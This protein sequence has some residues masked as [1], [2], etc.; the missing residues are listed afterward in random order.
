M[1]KMDMQRSAPVYWEQSVES[2]NTR[3]LALANKGAVSGTVFYADSQSGGKGRHGRSFISPEGGLYMSMLI[4]PS[5]EAEKCSQ[6]TP[7]AAVAAHR[8][9]KAC[10]GL[11]ADIKWPNDLQLGGK[12]LCG[13]LTELSFD[14]KGKPQIIIGIGINLNTPSF[15]EEL[16]DIACSVYSHSGKSIKKESLLE[17]LVKELDVYIARWE[18][19]GNFFLEEYRSLSVCADR[20]VIVISGTESK[21]AKALGIN[22]DFGL[23]VR[24]EDGIEESIFFGEVSL[25][26]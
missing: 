19:E 8:A 16:E 4:R 14:Q 13:I 1:D 9:L 12:K 11:H 6:L 5:C 22:D 23:R 7:L 20:E 10:T 2:T 25:R 17:R 15:T 18:E 24:Y 21:K 26:I 3:L